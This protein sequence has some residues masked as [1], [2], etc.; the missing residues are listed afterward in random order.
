MKNSTDKGHDKDRSTKNLDLLAMNRRRVNS[1]M[2]AQVVGK[3]IRNPKMKLAH[4]VH[5]IF[6]LARYLSAQ[7]SGPPILNPQGI[8]NNASYAPGS[9]A[10]APGSIA[11]VFGA[12]LT[13]GTSCVHASG[14][15]QTFDSTG[16]L[17]TTMDG[18]EVLINGSPVPIFYATPGQLGIQIPNELTGTSATLQ[19]I[20]KG[21]SS[22]A[23]TFAVAPFSPGIFS[24]NQQGSGPGAK[25]H[26][27]GTVVSPSS[28]AKPGETVTI[29]A[30]GLGQ[31]TPALATG[32]KPSAT[33][34]TVT[35]PTVTIDGW[36]TQACSRL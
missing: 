21:Q 22:P 23:Q 7:V 20:V 27:D 14:C 24:S 32:T 4:W 29:Y 12:N 31:V 11:A 10:L 2:K 15:D 13:D 19:V 35:T 6:S 8:V 18:A 36:L 17:G 28:P 16:R 33:V 26:A 3:V 1:S 25:T 30:T 34:S 9:N 5:L